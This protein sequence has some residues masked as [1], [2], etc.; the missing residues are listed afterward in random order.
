MTTHAASPVASVSGAYG[1]LGTLCGLNARAPSVDF[2]RTVAEVDCKSCRRSMAW[3]YYAHQMNQH[4]LK[5]PERPASVDRRREAGETATAGSIE[6][7]SA[8][9]SEA[10]ETP[11]V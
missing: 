7:E 3:S 5:L 9:R 11:H 2:A 4:G 6:D 10:K 8:V 1:V